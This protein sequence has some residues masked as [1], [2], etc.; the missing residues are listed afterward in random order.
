MMENQAYVFKNTLFDRAEM[1][2][3]F[4]DE[5]L[6][7]LYKGD[8]HLAVGD[9][10]SVLHRLFED[11]GSISI[12]KACGFFRFYTVVQVKDRILNFK[13]EGL[14]DLRSKKQLDT[15]VVTIHKAILDEQAKLNKH[16]NDFN[17]Q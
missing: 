11:I 16:V 17:S 5:I 7:R 1:N 13:L 3:S 15:I 8:K 4:G 14:K 2:L 12:W 9:L 10:S 6:L